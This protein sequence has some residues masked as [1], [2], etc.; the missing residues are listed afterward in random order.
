MKGAGI[1]TKINLLIRISI[2][3]SIPSAELCTRNL[4]NPGSL[5]EAKSGNEGKLETKDE[6][7]RISENKIQCWMIGKDE[8]IKESG[9]RV[10]C[11]IDAIVS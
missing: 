3:V 5:L 6:P 9:N 11:G 8:T 2:L 10:N 4:P 7:E 1:Y